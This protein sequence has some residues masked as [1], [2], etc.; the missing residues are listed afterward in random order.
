MTADLFIIK[1]GAILI[2]DLHRTI[3]MLT[4]EDYE[5]Q[6]RPNEGEVIESDEQVQQATE[7]GQLQVR[8]LRQ[9]LSWPDKGFVFELWPTSFKVVE[10]DLKSTFSQSLKVSLTT[11]RLDGLEFKFSAER[12]GEFEEIIH[13]GI[14]ADGKKKIFVQIKTPEV[15]VEVEMASQLTVTLPEFNITESIPISVRVKLQ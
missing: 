10:L 13:T 14:D 8:S 3:N 9:F 2:K 7:E 1:F 12:K 11:S 4:P 15:D 6:A 5:S